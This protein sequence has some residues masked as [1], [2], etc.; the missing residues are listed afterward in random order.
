MPAQVP[1]FHVMFWVQIH[2][3]PSEFMMVEVAKGLG[4]Y[5]G[6]FME[7]DAKNTSNLWRSFMRVRV[8]V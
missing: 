5:I 3:L 7:Y 1:L 8:N 4:D 2:D 6:V